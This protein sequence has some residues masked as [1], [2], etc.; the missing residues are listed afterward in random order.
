MSKKFVQHMSI[1]SVS[2][3]PQMDSD[4]DDYW[5]EPMDDG[6][7]VT[8]LFCNSSFHTT[9]ALWEHCKKA[10]QFDIA[11][12]KKYF[13]KFKPAEMINFLSML[14]LPQSLL[15]FSCS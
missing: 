7:E 9:C 11:H 2:E 10:H 13:S 1:S 6:Q 15:N 14:N 4:D 12:V 5:D 3:G 8:C